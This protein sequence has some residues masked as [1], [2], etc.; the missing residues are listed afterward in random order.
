MRNRARRRNE[1][2]PSGRRHVA[3]AHRP[4]C[5]V[6]CPLEVMARKPGNVHRRPDFRRRAALHFLRSRRGRP[7]PEMAA[8][9]AG[10]GPTMLAAVRSTTRAAAGTNTHLGTILL[11]APLAAV[12]STADLPPASTLF[13]TP[14]SR[15]RFAAAYKA[16]RLAGP[17]GLGRAP[18]TM[19]AATPTVPL[20]A[21]WPTPPTA[22]WS[23]GSTRTGFADV[24]TLGLP[25]WQ[26]RLADGP[27][28]DRHHRV[29]PP[30]VPRPPRGHP[31]HPR[32]RPG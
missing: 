32:A 13:S 4:V 10:V 31:H 1:N 29:P 24:A 20:R 27:G 3:A 26:P 17:G 22:T 11:L 23:R 12:P 5:P 8:A 14:D 2:P 28:G 30:A 19:C 18:N 7:G 6:A 16:I 21:A 15:R 9:L 25:P